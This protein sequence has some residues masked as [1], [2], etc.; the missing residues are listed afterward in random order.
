MSDALLSPDEQELLL[1]VAE[2][3]LAHGLKRQR[4]CDVVP[5]EFPETLRKPGCSFVT[6]RLQREL[7]GCIGTVEAH[8]PLVQDVAQNAFSAGFRD[9]RFTPLQ[10]A[11]YAKLSLS[12]SLLSEPEPV[13]AETE[14]DLLKQ[15][16]SRRDGWILRYGEQR[17]VLLPAVWDAI[18]EPCD[19]LA[20][21]KRKARLP[22]EFWS[23]ELVVETFRAESFT[24][25]T[26]QRRLRIR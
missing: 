19:F 7:R 22:R 17:G 8:S 12:I 24:R 1:E 16:G 21:L 20:A 3:S 9:P 4:A 2:E 11:E 15:M 13:R 5:D 18:S 10:E 23:A 14:D 26:E 25:I 6:L